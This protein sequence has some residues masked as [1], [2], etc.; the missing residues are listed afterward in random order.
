MGW[1]EPLWRHSRLKAARGEWGHAAVTHSSGGTQLGGAGD[2]SHQHRLVARDGAQRVGT[3]GRVAV[4]P[5]RVSAKMW[6]ALSSGYSARSSSVADS[7]SLSS[8][9]LALSEV[10][11]MSRAPC[12]S[13]VEKEMG[14]QRGLLCRRLGFGK[15]LS[16]LSF[17][18]NSVSMSLSIHEKLR[19]QKTVFM[20]FCP[21][22]LPALSWNCMRFL[23]SSPVFRNTISVY[24][25][26][27]LYFFPI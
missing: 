20:I 12:F 16:N 6:W 13:R 14:E 26:T 4:G 1:L 11:L 8:H 10:L 19:V 25:L 27:H 2:Q 21:A 18:G 7:C 22:L 5:A 17:R 23:L 9:L 24:S 15:Y 3:H